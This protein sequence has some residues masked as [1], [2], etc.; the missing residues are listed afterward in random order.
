MRTKRLLISLM[1]CIS[2]SVFGGE[3]SSPNVQNQSQQPTNKQLQQENQELL[4]KIDNLEEE[5]MICRDDVRTKTVEIN[6]N[7]DNWLV[8]LSITMA[9]I[10]IVLGILTPLYINYRNDKSLKEEL[11]RM[12]EE[13]REQIALTKRDAESA[14]A[15]LSSITSQAVSE[16]DHLK[17][18][19]LYTKAISLFPN[20]TEAYNNRGILKKE[21]NDKEGAMRDYNKAIELNQDNSGSYNNRGILKKELNDFNGALSDYNKAIEL[22]PNNARYYNNRADLWM[23]LEEF[24][25]AMNDVNDAIEIDN[26]AYVSY[27]TR[28]EIYFTMNKPKEAI[29]D[30]NNAL[31]LD[32]DIKVAYEYRAQCYRKLAETEQDPTKKTDLIAKAEADE[33]KAESLKND[34]KHEV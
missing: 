33:K 8:I 10:G 5:V 26:K 16:K 29:I 15:S 9:M 32:S 2:L 19:E 11:K 3:P 14:K 31:S 7:L 1:M 6:D 28:G 24:G 34:I 18:I 17:A 23:I 30:F 12:N 27:V 20:I 13:L 4:N 21:L 25:K 22:N